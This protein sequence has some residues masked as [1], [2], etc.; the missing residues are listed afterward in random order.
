MVGETIENVVAGIVMKGAKE[1]YPILSLQFKDATLKALREKL[2]GITIHE[3]IRGKELVIDPFQDE[4]FLKMIQMILDIVEYHPDKNVEF[5]INITGGTNLMSAAAEA[6][7]VL[8]RS[9]AY[10]VVKGM[11]GSRSNVIILPWHSMDPN[12][13]KGIR[14]SILRT[15]EHTS[16]SNN[17]IVDALYDKVTKK[18]I[19]RYLQEFE[20]A[21][22]IT[23]VRK[24]KITVNEITPW[25]TIAI[26]LGS[27]D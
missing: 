5:W 6:G 10:Y 7:A 12:T 3:N 26:R 17:G 4:S 9:K 22:Y 11:D 24:G 25:G 18:S 20:K 23:R 13:I 16:M 27:R 15:I 1:L 14:L 21:G 8:T 2:S 19:V